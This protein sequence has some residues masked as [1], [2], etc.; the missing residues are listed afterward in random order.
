[1]GRQEPRLWRDRLRGCSP[2]QEQQH[3][4]HTGCW[5]H[6]GM[7][8]TYQG[9]AGGEEVQAAQPHSPPR[10]KYIIIHLYH[11]PM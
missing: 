4:I 3:D 7:L 5:W 2:A 1:M 10:S 9:L 8:G 6:W 11:C